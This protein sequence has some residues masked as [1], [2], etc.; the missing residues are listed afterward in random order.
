MKKNILNFQEKIE[1]ILETLSHNDM[2]M[3]AS[4]F[5]IEENGSL[6]HRQIHI[7]NYW[8]NT[9]KEGF[10]PRFFKKEYARYRFSTLQIDGKAL[11]ANA[12]EFLTIDLESFKKR[13]QDYLE[14]QLKEEIQDKT[15]YRYFYVYNENAS[16]DTLRI[17]Y[18]TIEY[19]QLL[20]PNSF[21]IKVIAPKY[22]KDRFNV[23]PYQGKLIFFEQKIIILFHNKYDYIAAIFNKE[24]TT[25]YTPYTVGVSIGISD[26]NQKTPV[27]KKA[28]LSQSILKEFDELYLT[29]NETEIIMAQEGFFSLNIAKEE[30]NK[31]HLSKVSQKIN[32]INLFLQNASQKSFRALEYKVAF[33]EFRAISRIMQ[34]VASSK[35]FYVNSR[36]RVLESVLDSFA[37]KP[38]RELYIVMPILNKYNVFRYYSPTAKRLIEK[39]QKLSQCVS[40]ELICV[41]ERCVSSFPVEIEDFLNELKE[42]ISISFVYAKS[43]DSEV[44]SYD[45]IF[46]DNKD[47]IFAKLTRSRVPAFRFF[48]DST[49]L[50]DYES[51]FYKIKKYA[52]SFE[53]FE[54]NKSLFCAEGKNKQLEKF[55]GTWHLYFQ[56]SKQFWYNQLKIYGDA[57]VELLNELRVI[58]KGRLFVKQKQSAI[59]L[60]DIMSSNLTTMQFDNG[61]YN[62]K[63]GFLVNMI[64][65][66]YMSEND[67][68]TV[69][70]CIKDE[71]SLQEAQDI[72]SIEESKAFYLD[73]GVI[74]E[75]LKEYLI[76][77]YGYY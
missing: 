8:L 46:S 39:F 53:K 58:A 3:L 45:F 60:E 63:K 44:N 74:K 54:K 73:N 62:M 50:D 68:F 72:L 75:R 23:T 21:A 67:I 56:G 35:T 13:I 4:W 28:I 25:S 6:E 49:T 55:V 77:R 32:N 29:L 70:V 64:G 52:V 43:I 47:F 10:A 1:Y 31:A 65:K 33:R 42:H 38:F 41:I 26:F 19:Q 17:D 71:I 30:Q 66:Q 14:S 12:N 27:A 16:L 7:K 20:S 48:S 76:G 57:Q 24:L 40:I 61:G 51:H 9:Q 5:W 34:N 36:E 2:E 59:I 69:G 15:R 18:Y 11:F 22:K 37:Y